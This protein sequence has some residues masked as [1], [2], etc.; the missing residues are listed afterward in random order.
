MIMTTTPPT[1]LNIFQEELSATTCPTL[2]L[3]GVKDEVVPH[4]HSL[5]LY[6]ASSASLKVNSTEGTGCCWGT[7]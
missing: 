7:R 4:T 1:S 2:M 3:H 6:R 5:E